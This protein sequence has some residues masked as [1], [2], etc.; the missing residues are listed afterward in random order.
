MN[1][2]ILQKRLKRLGIAVAVIS[3]A[4]LAAGSLASFY[5][6]NILGDA[7]TGQMKSDADQY[8]TNILRQMDADLQTLDTLGSLLQYKD[9]ESLIRRFG[10]TK[11]HND[12]EQISFYGSSGTEAAAA[13][14]A[15]SVRTVIEEAW[16][17]NSGVSRIYQEDGS[18]RNIFTYAVPVCPEGAVE[19]VLTASVGTDVF[20]DILQ[21]DT[22]LGRTGYV[23]LIS[24]SGKVLVRSS[25]RIVSEDL[26][27]I[28]DNGYILPEE[29]E[30]ISRAMAE[31]EVCLSSFTY[32]GSTYQVLLEPVG[33]NG[34]YLFCVQTM[35][36][37]SR[38]VYNLMTN[39]R[40]ISGGIL[41]LILVIIAYGYRLIRRGNR[42]LIRNTY[43]DP[44]TGSYNRRRFEYEI[45]PLIK[46]SCEYSIAALNVRQ[47]KFINEIFGSRAADELLCHIRKVIAENVRAGEYYCRS[48]EDLF[49]LFLRDTD[50]T[51]IRER[52]K[53]IID[54]AAACRFGGRGDYEILMYCGV[55]IG[56]ELAEEDPDVQKSMTH[57]RFALD[58]ART[59]LKNNIWFYDTELHET[60]IL[61][62]YIETHMNQ[63][64]EN[65]EFKMF[66]QPK[67]DLQTGAVG[68]AEALVRWVPDTGNMIR[69][70]QFIPVFE[71][72]G[73]C[74]S[75]D[76]YMAEQ[77]CRQIRRWIDA[78]LCPVP[79]SVNQSRLL[80]YETDYIDRMRELLDRYRI[81]GH[82]I[83]LEILEG[84]AAENAGVLNEKILRLKE[85]GL[86]IS[87]D[88][89]G[90]GYSSLNT[91]AGLKI[92]E[93]KFDRDF[94]LRLDDKEVDRSRQLVI[95]NEI[96]EL[97]KKL[98]IR[99]VAE[100]V[101]TKEH[102]ELIRSFGCGYGQGYYYGRPVSAEVFS[103]KYLGQ[104]SA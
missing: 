18:G 34:W 104:K 70:D 36:G 6:R 67:I 66:L 3:A 46:K 80:F 29:K 101:E 76:M 56:S 98:N 55:V 30:E 90:S 20:L 13:L 35:Q 58:T 71:K 87:M 77:A 102:E 88:D 69:P 26:D 54:G 86:R 97:T 95:M 64:L 37:A 103:E 74:S 68:G 53:K 15:E 2:R 1:E 72:N 38:S 59:S 99:T 100:G 10:Q 91:L 27:T 89:F 33:V 62:N 21:D 45:G 9:A 28:Y 78:G 22:I 14:P 73:F 60:E 48:F 75:L 61:E 12:F 50:R 32:E 93:L 52:I 42:E 63:A 19:G 44:L 39:M 49:Y 4:I 23:H 82:M 5:L 84:L 51:A 81:P 7:L 25:N 65:R 24:D 8:R 41:L 85:L 17:G 96:V 16:K 92:D 57:V 31:G 94:L 83:T 47:F 79:I 11:G 43:Y 40:L